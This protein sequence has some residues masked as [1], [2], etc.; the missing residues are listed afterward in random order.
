MNLYIPCLNKSIFNDTVLF[1]CTRHY[2][3]KWQVNLLFI[4]CIIFTLQI[5]HDSHPISIILLFLGKKKEN[6][7]Q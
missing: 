3:E 1:H 6:R 4:S 5:Y 2:I 7:L